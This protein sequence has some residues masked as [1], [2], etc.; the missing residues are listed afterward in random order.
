M[1]M[2]FEVQDLA[3]ASPATVSRCGMVYMTPEDLSWRPYVKSRIDVFFDDDS[4]LDSDLKKYLYETF[5][6]TIDAG[7]KKIAG[8]LHEPI[9]T[10][11]IQKATNVLNFLEAILRP[12]YGFKGKKEDKQKLLN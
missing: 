6:Q 8:G 7:L 9:P 12:E 4:I 5:D 11:P 10:V 3:V 2:L 1:R